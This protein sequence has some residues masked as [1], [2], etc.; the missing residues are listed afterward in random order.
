MIDSPVSCFIRLLFLHLK[1]LQQPLDYF[2]DAFL[3]SEV[4]SSP[5]MRISVLDDQLVFVVEELGAL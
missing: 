1:L 3:T 4:E 5:S 2:F